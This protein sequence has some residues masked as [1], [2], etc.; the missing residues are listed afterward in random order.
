MEE[1]MTQNWRCQNCQSINHPRRTTCWRCGRG[2]GKATS[3]RSAGSIEMERA[4]IQRALIQSSFQQDKPSEKITLFFGSLLL[5]L[6]S[7]TFLTEPVRSPNI[8]FNWGTFTIGL[9][10]LALG[11]GSAAFQGKRMFVIETCLVFISGGIYIGT[12]S[13]D[14]INPDLTETANSVCHGQVITTSAEYSPEIKNHPIV[15]IYQ[16]T[17]KSLKASDYPPGWLPTTVTTL[18]LAACIEETWK[19]IES[20]AYEKNSFVNRKQ[21]SLIVTVLTTSQGRQIDQ[22]KL[23]GGIPKECGIIESFEDNEKV[24]TLQ[25]SAVSLQQVIDQLVSLTAQ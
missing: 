7:I 18:Q 6:F 13:S 19:T 14:R 16:A 17:G 10:L 8:S 1:I 9:F 24:K 5:F 20:C 12:I 2:F 23:L 11:L 21:H 22:F 3:A 4:I 25:G 15:I